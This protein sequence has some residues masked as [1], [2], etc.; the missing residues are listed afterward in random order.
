M[1]DLVNYGSIKAE[2]DKNTKN[3]A[4]SVM[5]AGIAGITNGTTNITAARNLVYNCVNYGDMT[6]SVPRTS[7][8]VSAVNQ[9]T[10]VEL[11]KNYGNQTNSN[12]GTRVGMITAIMANYTSLK[13]CE[14][15]GDAIMTGGTGA[16]VGGLVC[17][18]NHTSCTISGGGN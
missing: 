9:Y 17:L 2:G 18:L 5:A 8:I 1:K 10:D 11:C 12:S 4:T 7:G 13:D 14:N 16:Q 3:G 6:S 15:H